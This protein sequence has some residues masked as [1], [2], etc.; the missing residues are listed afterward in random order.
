MVIDV[1]RWCAERLT[2]RTFLFINQHESKL[3]FA[4][5]DALNCVLGGAWKKLPRGWNFIHRGPRESTPRARREITHFAGGVKPW[6]VECTNPEQG[7]YLHYRSKTP[8]KDK[9]LV[10]RFERHIAKITQKRIRQ[11]IVIFRRLNHSRGSP[12]QSSLEARHLTPRPGPQS[13][14]AI[15]NAGD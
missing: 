9:R 8:W 15:S 5:Q 1:A 3:R 12:L 14:P 2:E 7:L 4:E 13:W 10:T 6:S 11:A